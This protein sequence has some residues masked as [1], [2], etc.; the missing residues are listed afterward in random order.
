MANLNDTLLNVYSR[1]ILSS[2]GHYYNP[3]IDA[4]AIS[5]SCYTEIFVG[6]EE[7]EIPCF[8]FR[9]LDRKSVV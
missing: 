3:N 2:N 4:Q 8:A 5:D 9:T 6:D 1:A 7:F